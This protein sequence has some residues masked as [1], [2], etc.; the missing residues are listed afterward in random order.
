[1]DPTIQRTK[2]VQISRIRTREHRE[3]IPEL[4]ELL[5]GKLSERKVSRGLRP[6]V[7]LDAVNGK[8]L[9]LWSGIE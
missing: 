2:L 5:L 7:R 8:I 3:F 9:S 4:E 1:M 6:D